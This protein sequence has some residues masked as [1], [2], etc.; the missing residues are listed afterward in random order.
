MAKD[1]VLPNPISRWKWERA[2]TP[3]SKCKQCLQ[4][5]AQDA[6]RLKSQDPDPRTRSAYDTSRCQLCGL[7]MIEEAK[8]ILGK[9]T[10]PELVPREVS[11]FEV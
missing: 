8:Q 4:P 11:V 9:I 3:R 1:K 2:K 6:W 10:N 5:I 7:K